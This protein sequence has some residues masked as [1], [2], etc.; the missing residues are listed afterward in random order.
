MWKVY[1]SAEAVLRVESQVAK[2]QLSFATQCVTMAV[3]SEGEA[4][5]L[6]VEIQK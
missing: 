6:F 3:K 1:E 5:D 2:V 4:K